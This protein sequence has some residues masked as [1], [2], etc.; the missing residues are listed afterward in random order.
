MNSPLPRS[1]QP[2]AQGGEGVKKSTSRVIPSEDSMILRLTTVHDPLTRPTTADENAVV[3]HPLPQ[4][5]EGRFSI[6]IHRGEPKDHEV[7]ARNDR[8]AF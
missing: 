1:D 8:L 3:G 4:G 2:S 7:F 5:G 6:F